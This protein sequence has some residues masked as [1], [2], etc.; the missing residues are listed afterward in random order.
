M[1]LFPSILWYLHAFR[2]TCNGSN[3]M[4]LTI[5]PSG[6]IF[7]TVFFLF[8]ASFTLILSTYYFCSWDPFSCPLFI[9]LVIYLVYKTG[10]L[11]SFGSCPG[12]RS[13]RPGWLRT[14]RDLPAS[15]SQ[16]LG[17]KA[18]ATTTLLCLSILK[19][20]L[21]M[22]CSI[23]DITFLKSLKKY[24]GEGRSFQSSEQCR[25]PRMVIPWLGRK[26]AVYAM[27]PA[28]ERHRKVGNS[29]PRTLHIIGPLS[30]LTE[31]MQA[32]LS[33]FQN[34]HDTSFYLSLPLSS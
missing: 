18:C 4:L 20:N 30:L 24:K 7:M 32:I 1:K 27:K 3:W 10:F 26:R 34:E 19:A 2:D 5:A 6:R 14:H 16:V 29:F 15:A 13:C 25:L 8:P 9:Y 33:H 12:T 11:C 23:W 22:N 28:W 31:P 21:E 17:L